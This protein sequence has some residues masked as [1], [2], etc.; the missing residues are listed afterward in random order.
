[1]IRFEARHFKR[2]ARTGRAGAL[3]D[4]SMLCELFHENSKLT[5]LSAPA[6]RAEIDLFDRAARMARVARAPRKVHSLADT[7]ELPD[8]GPP[9]NA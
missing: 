4:G 6:V 5:P 2:L 8:A 7:A 1:M 9:A 3:S